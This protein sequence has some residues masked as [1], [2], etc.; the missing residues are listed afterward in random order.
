MRRHIT[1]IVTKT[2]L[3]AFSFNKIN[4]FLLHYGLQYFLAHVFKRAILHAGWQHLLDIFKRRLRALLLATC[5]RG[6]ATQASDF[7]ISS[8]VHAFTAAV[9]W[10]LPFCTIRSADAFAPCRTVIKIKPS[11]IRSSYL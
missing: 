6:Q 11:L 9:T 8:Y 5:K 3:L 4:C 7:S 10:Q 2:L 1:S